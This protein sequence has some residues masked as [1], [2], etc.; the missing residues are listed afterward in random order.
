M[1]RRV[2]LAAL[3]LV[4]VL[5]CGTVG[6]MLIE[7]WNLIDSLY[8]TA[9]TITTV[10]FG[11]VASLDV[12]GRLFTM[13]LIAVGVAG[14]GY[15]VGTIVEFAVEG[16]L[17]GILGGRRMEKRIGALRD[18]QVVVGLG[19]VGSI[20]AQ[21]LADKGVPFVVVDSSEESLLAA[22]DAGWLYVHG[23][24][25][26]EETLL[27][28]GIASAKGLVTALD[29]DADNLFV[30]LTARTLNPSLF[31]VARSSSV[32]SEA[33]I[34]RSGADR[35]LTPNVIGGRRMASMVLDPVVTDYL[36]VVMH[37]DRLEYKL[38]SLVVAKDGRLEGR[39]IR[40]ARVRT[41]TGAYILA[42]LPSGG[43][44]D[45]DP[46]A[47]TVLR[48]GDSLIVLGTSAQLETLARL[49]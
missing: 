37:G 30:A 33:K 8:M 31:I 27:H 10:G 17:T 11:E 44:L 22:R 13:G 12:A 48:A 2:R 3:V 7:H 26:E 28:A 19:R 36:D 16:Y 14:I 34:L 32:A 6:Y 35:V 21:A 20:V 1:G 29:T 39:S 4:G 43:T 9:I 49:L 24:A 41:E 18:H 42:V 25:T 38:E 23:D 40:E 47:D 45:T 15:S 46:A 5:T